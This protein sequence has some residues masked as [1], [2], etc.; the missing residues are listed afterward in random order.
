MLFIAQ[1]LIGI[2]TAAGHRWGSMWSAQT[3][4]PYLWSLLTLRPDLSFVEPLPPTVKLHIAVAWFIVLLFP[5]SRLVHMF[6]IPIQYLWRLPQLVIWTNARRIEHLAPVL[7]TAQESRR[8]F[9]RGA[10]GLGSAGG[11]LTIGVMDKL[12]RFFSGPN[13]TPE[14]QASLLTKRLQRLEMTAEERELELERMR[15]E[16]IF[17]ANL[18][19][20]SPK[21]GKYFIDY[22]MRPALAYRDASGLPRL[23]SAKCTHLGCTVASTVDSNGRVLCPCH[24]SYFDLKTGMP[25]AGLA[26]DKAVAVAGLGTDGRRRKNSD[27]PGAEGKTEGE[28]PADQLDALKVYIAKRY[29][30][31]A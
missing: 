2:Q 26:R 18:K 15:N 14:E 3:T 23:I 31:I 1:V 19:D 29:E 8:L 9:L 27:E 12:V 7:R 22:Q 24:M 21:D 25:Q 4:T 11:L 28:I 6:S 10:V 13:M 16:Y 20:L 17:V 30:E 5:F